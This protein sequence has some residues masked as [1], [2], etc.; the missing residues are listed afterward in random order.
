VL[1]K[2]EVVGSIPSGSTKVWTGVKARFGRGF[3]L[4]SLSMRFISFAGRERA[5]H[6]E[7]RTAGDEDLCPPPFLP[8][9]DL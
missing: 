7:G 5:R 4:L 1:C 9:L 6:E 2:H 3:P 8:V